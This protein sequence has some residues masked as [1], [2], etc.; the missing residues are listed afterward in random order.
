MNNPEKI[1]SEIEEIGSLKKIV[2]SDE[3]DLYT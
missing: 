3:K 1:I 2:E